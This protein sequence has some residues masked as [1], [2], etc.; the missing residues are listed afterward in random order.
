MNRIDEQQTVVWT[1]VAIEF[2]LEQQLDTQCGNDEIIVVENA[3]YGRMRLNR[4][5]HTDYGFIGCGTDV[6]DVLAGKCS[7]R[8][9]CQV[10]NIEAL[11]AASRVCPTDLK[12]YLE[13]SF[14]CV[15][16]LSLCSSVCLTICLSARL[17]VST[18]SFKNV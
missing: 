10:V 5:V 13:A 18:K 16:G 2:C 3:S 1:V 6:T 14:T 17:A 12:S 7:G 11:F 9:R 8:R 15:K 4:C